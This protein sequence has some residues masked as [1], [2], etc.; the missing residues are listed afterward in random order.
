SD[1]IANLNLQTGLAATTG[2][3]TIITG[4]GTLTLINF[5]TVTNLN[6]A[7]DD[8][9]ADV[10]GLLSLTTGSHSFTVADATNAPVDLEVTASVSGT[11]GFTK[12]GLGTMR[13][14]AGT[15]T[16]TGAIDINAGTVLVDTIVDKG[17]AVTVNSGGTLGGTRNQVVTPVGGVVGPT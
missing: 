7:T 8:T 1:I 4:A 15:N 6:A 2:A 11:G 17:A 10:N 9:G 5:L 13:L 14:I 12:N 3:S 16:F